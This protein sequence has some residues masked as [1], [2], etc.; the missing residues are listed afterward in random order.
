MQPSAVTQ[1]HVCFDVQHAPR[2][3]VHPLVLQVSQAFPLFP[4]YAV[5]VVVRHLPWE[6]QQPEEQMALH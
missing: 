4:Q 5:E 3:R 6:S 1:P 2:L